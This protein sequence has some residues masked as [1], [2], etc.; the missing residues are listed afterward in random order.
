MYE[1]ASLE[2]ETNRNH[3]KKLY[4]DGHN[5]EDGQKD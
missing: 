4:S 3:S 5:T 1:K 2:A